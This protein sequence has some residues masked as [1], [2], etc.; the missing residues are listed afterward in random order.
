MFIATVGAAIGAFHSLSNLTSA[1]I[2]WAG[3][4]FSNFIVNFVI[5]KVP[6]L[7]SSQP[8]KYLYKGLLTGLFV[9]SI[10]SKEFGPIM[11]IAIASV[12]SNAL[13]DYYTVQTET[14][15]GAHNTAWWNTL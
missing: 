6:N 7:P 4:I 10:I 8:H 13:Y 9:Y 15:E 1:L 14:F 12:V 5:V 11:E 2:A 3:A